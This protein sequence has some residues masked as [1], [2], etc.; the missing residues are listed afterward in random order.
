VLAGGQAAVV[1]AS[2][3]ELYLPGPA[4]QA[5]HGATH[6]PTAFSSLCSQGTPGSLAIF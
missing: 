2:S 6:L 1:P 5:H 3:L 4:K